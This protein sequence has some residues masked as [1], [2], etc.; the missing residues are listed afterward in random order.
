MGDESYI[1]PKRAARLAGVTTKTLYKWLR[2]GHIKGRRQGP[3]MWV[4]KESDVVKVRR[5]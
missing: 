5:G 3:K 4:I 2:E 1:T